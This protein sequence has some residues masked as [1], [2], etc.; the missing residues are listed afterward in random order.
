MLKNNNDKDNKRMSFNATDKK[1]IEKHTKIWEKVTNL[2]N[3]EFDS[4][5]VYGNNDKNIK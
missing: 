1:L 2:L 3:E 5:S 4:E